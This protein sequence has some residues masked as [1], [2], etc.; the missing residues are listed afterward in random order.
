MIHRGFLE[1]E[2]IGGSKEIVMGFTNKSLKNIF[3]DLSLVLLV[4][5]LAIALCFASSRLRKA[6]HQSRRPHSVSDSNKVKTLRTRWLV[7]I[8]GGLF[9]GTVEVAIGFVSGGFAVAMARRSLRFLGRTCLLFGI[10][11]GYVVAAIPDTS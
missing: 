5:F 11:Q 3:D 9:I 1:T 4:L 6:Q 10:I 7:W 2:V 8:V